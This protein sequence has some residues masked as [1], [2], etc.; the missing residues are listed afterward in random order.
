MGTANVQLRLNIARF[1]KL[2]DDCAFVYNSVKE[3]NG[4]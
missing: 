2:W 1:M 4:L 3:M